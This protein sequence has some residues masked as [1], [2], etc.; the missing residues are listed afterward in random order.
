M[1]RET[2]D[3]AEPSVLLPRPE[4]GVIVSPLTRV[5]ISE[6]AA[7]RLRQTWTTVNLGQRKQNSK[8]DLAADVKQVCER[9]GYFRIDLTFNLWLKIL[10]HE[11]RK[12]R[13]LAAENC[14]DRCHDDN[15]ARIDSPGWIYGSPARLE[16]N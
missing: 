16:G 11:L 3:R 7:S 15:E 5:G 4:E 1:T 12:G 6:T 8:K 14:R 9:P 10:D 13:L 2:S